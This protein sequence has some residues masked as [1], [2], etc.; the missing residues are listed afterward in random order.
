MRL[1]SRAAGSRS[2]R[3]TRN[4]TRA[5]YAAPRKT[6]SARLGSRVVQA[7]APAIAASTVVRNV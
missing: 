3:C 7:S 2:P 4:E 6:T 5:P 1:P